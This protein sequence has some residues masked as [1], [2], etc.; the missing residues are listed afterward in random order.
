MTTRAR[1]RT[2]TRTVPPIEGIESVERIL[3]AVLF[4][5]DGTTYEGA[6]L[7][8]RCSPTEALEARVAVLPRIAGRDLVA[9]SSALGLPPDALALVVTARSRFLKES[10]VLAI[11]SADALH[12]D[13]RLDLSG[14]PRP[15]PLQAIHTGF[16]ISAALVLGSERPRERMRPWRRGT[17][18]ATA[19]F[20]VIT[21]PEGG[22]QPTPMDDDLRKAL[23]IP[24]G[25]SRFVR[26]LGKSW[27]AE[28]PADCVDVY[29]DS[30]LLHLMSQGSKARRDMQRELVAF[31]F[32]SIVN[33]AARDSELPDSWDADIERSVLGQ[34]LARTASGASTTPEALFQALSDT[35]E[36][37]V[38]HIDAMAGLQ[39]GFARILK[40]GDASQ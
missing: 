36:L 10:A 9:G 11:V 5:V 7:A 40:G 27:R 23:G 4:E 1:R 12:E 24:A 25:T 13:L 32:T 37:V 2:E 39:G 26:H 3:D 8:H 33:H 15:R 21:E 18:L 20:S 29:V 31:V 35:P 22:F 30:Q 16:E 19:S 6:G 34:V 38:A 14:P 28:Q 17:I